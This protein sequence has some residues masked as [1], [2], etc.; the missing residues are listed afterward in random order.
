MVRYRVRVRIMNELVR[1]CVQ[2]V[3]AGRGNAR[4]ALFK[5]IFVVKFS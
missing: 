3:V 2:I 4:E 5:V 1:F